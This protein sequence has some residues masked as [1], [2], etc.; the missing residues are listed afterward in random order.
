MFLLEVAPHLRG[1]FWVATSQ[2]AASGEA[3]ALYIALSGTVQTVRGV[4]R[5]VAME[6][7]RLLLR[8]H[9][10]NPEGIQ[11]GFGEDDGAAAS[12]VLLPGVFRE[13]PSKSAEPVTPPHGTDVQAL[14]ADATRD[15]PEQKTAVYSGAERKLIE[16]MAQGAA[17]PWSGGLKPL[18]TVG[19]YQL[20]ERLARGRATEVY[21][22]RVLLDGGVEKLVALKV[23]LPQ[24]GPGTPDGQAFVAAAQ[25]AASLQHRGAVPVFDTGEAAGRLYLAMQYVEGRSLEVLVRCM[26]ESGGPSKPFALQVMLEVARA[27]VQLHAAGRAHGGLEPSNVLVSEQGEVKLIDAAAGGTLQADVAAASALLRELLVPLPSPVGSVATA[28]ELAAALSAELAKGGAAD[29][30]MMVRALCGL[31]LS[32]EKRHVAKL[33]LEA[34]VARPAKQRT[35]RRR[36]VRAGLAVAAV[37]ALAA[38]AVAV[39]EL[40]DGQVLEQQLRAVDERMS[41]GA[42]SGQGETAL[43]ALAAARQAGPTDPRV[44]ERAAQLARAFEQLGDAAA[45]RGDDAEAAAHFAALSVADPGRP[46]ALE[47][48]ITARLK[49]AASTARRE[50]GTNPEP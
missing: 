18:D 15:E 2:V 28:A 6:P 33:T 24:H 43:S 44:R 34:R 23:T 13:A 31:S 21:V 48:L 40:F 29:P 20:L 45:G 47:K 35:T 39:K 10:L 42:L 4:A 12:D 17:L 9:S 11:F 36:S 38:G 41:A 30:G 16:S 14:L 50:V 37:L 1:Q 27:L 25:H 26:R 19:N 49:S 8:V 5:V 46:G 3:V 32:S 22:A 7:G